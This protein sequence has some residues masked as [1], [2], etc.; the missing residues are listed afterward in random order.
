MTVD[1]T[2][3]TISLSQGSEVSVSDSLGVCE[4]ERCGVDGSLLTK[5]AR[6]FYFQ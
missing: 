1:S 2:V 4:S 5:S 6:Q 3:I